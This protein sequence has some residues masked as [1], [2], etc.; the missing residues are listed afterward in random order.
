MAYN[1]LLVKGHLYAFVNQKA[2]DGTPFCHLLVEDT[3]AGLA[4][5]AAIK[6]ASLLFDQAK[7]KLDDLGAQYKRKDGAPLHVFDPAGL[8]R[9]AVVVEPSGPAAPTPA[10]PEVIP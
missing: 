10:L 7:D 8:A 4:L 6:A 2:S 3:P 1:E 9:P 5:V